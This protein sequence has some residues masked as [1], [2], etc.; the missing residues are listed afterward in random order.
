[1]AT[2]TAQRSSEAPCTLDKLITG[3]RVRVSSVKRN[4]VALYLKLVTMGIIPGSIIEVSRVAPL[5]D[6]IAIRTTGH[7][8]SLRL[9]EAETVEV[10]PSGAR[11]VVLAP[12]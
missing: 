4:D 3:K 6:P 2:D 10:D 12:K 1:M 11:D 5:G 9:S 8:L 7:S